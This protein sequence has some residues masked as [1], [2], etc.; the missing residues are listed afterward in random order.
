[1]PADPKGIDNRSRRPSLPETFFTGGA[2]SSTAR[3]SKPA[4][5]FLVQGGS[6]GIG[7][8]GDPDG[9]G[10]RQPGLRHRRQRGE[11]PQPARSSAPT[12]AINYKTEDF[13]AAVKEATGAR[14]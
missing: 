9:Q 2:T 6:S 7:V 3:G 13:V 8:T 11:V 5:P 1:V 14:A 12:V 4:S 10:V